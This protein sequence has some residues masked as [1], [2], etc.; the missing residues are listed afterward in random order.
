MQAA[1]EAARRRS[2]ADLPLALPTSG[3]SYLVDRY[4]QGRRDQLGRLQPARCPARVVFADTTF[5][6]G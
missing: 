4:L 3:P 5:L 1:G 6:R 2:A